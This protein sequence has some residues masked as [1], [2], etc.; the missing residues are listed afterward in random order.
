MRVLDI[1]CGV[2][3]VSLLAGRLVGP[4]GFVLG[5]DRSADAI[6]VAERRASQA[7]QCYWTRFT[8]AELDAFSCDQQFD[9]VIGRL[10]LMYLPDPVATLRSLTR[11]VRPGGVVAFQELALPLARTVPEVPL[12][13]RCRG[14]VAATIERAGFEIDM[15]G[16]LP[17]A[18][19][20]AGLPAPQMSSAALIGSGP[21][22]PIYAYIADTVRSLLPMAESLGVATAGE[23]EID[24][25]ADRL[26][27]E[28][29]ERQACVMPTCLVG[30]WAT[31]QA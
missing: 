8:A 20:A 14:W 9:A 3:D 4:T 19:A 28:A 12:F 6:D 22:T 29:V 31:T 1:G 27:S 7:G 23:V 24:T 30:A 15:G 16:K 18:F 11:F 2:G 25:L 17:A 5:V 13:S 10:V 26:R 21:E